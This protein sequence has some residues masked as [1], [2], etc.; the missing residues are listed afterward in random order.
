MVFPLPVGPINP[1][2]VL[3]GILKLILFTFSAAALADSDGAFCVTSEYVA[4]EAKGIYIPVKEPSWIIVS[5]SAKGIGSKEYVPLTSERAELVCKTEDTLQQGQLAYIDKSEV[6]ALLT[7]KDQGHISIVTSL[8]RDNQVVDGG[9]S[10]F[11]YFSLTITHAENINFL[12]NSQL[13]ATCMR[14]I[15]IH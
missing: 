4:V 11:N 7:L 2:V 1:I 5:Y 6:K 3:A 15:S 10:I 14:F 9:G 13:V 12:K 8:V